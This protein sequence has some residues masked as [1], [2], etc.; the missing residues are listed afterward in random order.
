MKRPESLFKPKE[1]AEVP[2][3][4]KP[5]EAGGP[6][7]LLQSSSSAADITQLDSC[8]SFG[9]SPGNWPRVYPFGSVD[10]PGE[11]Y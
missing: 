5:W 1:Q 2:V 11:I 9:E 8:L 10:I 6:G 3:K 7:E 4:T